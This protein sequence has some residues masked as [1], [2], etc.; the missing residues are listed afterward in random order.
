MRQACWT[1]LGGLTLAGF[2]AACGY[3]DFEFRERGEGG[4]ATQTAIPTGTGLG[5][6][7]GYGGTATGTPPVSR[8]ISG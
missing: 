3:P 5:G 4:L 8:V 2:A 1:V 6:T 7:G